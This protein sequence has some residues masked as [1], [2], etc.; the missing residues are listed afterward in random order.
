MDYSSQKNEEKQLY[1]IRKLEI[2]MQKRM[3]EEQTNQALLTKAATLTKHIEFLENILKEKDQKQQKLEKEKIKLK[4]ESQEISEKYQR[5]IET[6]E[7]QNE[8]ELLRGKKQKSQIEDQEFKRKKL[9]RKSQVLQ[10][11]LEDS[12]QEKAK[13][14][15]E[16]SSKKN[17]YESSIKSL[18]E[19]VRELKAYTQ[20]LENSISISLS[21][22]KKS[23]EKLK[24]NKKE[25][26]VLLEEQKKIEEKLFQYKN[27]SDKQ[28]EDIHLKIKELKKEKKEQDKIINQFKTQEERFQEKLRELFI[29]K[30]TY[31]VKKIGEIKKSEN[32]Y[33]LL[34]IEILSDPQR[35]VARLLDFGSSKK[36]PLVFEARV[37]DLEIEKNQSYDQKFLIIKRGQQKI[38]L[39]TDKTP[40]IVELLG[41]FDRINF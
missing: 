17:Q 33:F 39:E 11:L 1:F 15:E 2:Y 38:F 30:K 4:N 35:I 22:I 29:P 13:L 34:Q 27:S 7:M 40:E 24:E 36:S 23:S 6:N 26:E 31:I 3:A 28:I 21:N 12:K 5:L 20:T 18:E 19:K 9:E 32:Q 41:T 37:T 8:N 25:N 14:S 16:L 10:D